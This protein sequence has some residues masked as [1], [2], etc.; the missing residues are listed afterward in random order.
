MPKTQQKGFILIYTL[1]IAAVIAVVIGITIASA[2]TELRISRDEVESLKAFYAADTGIECV[3]FYQ[4][5]YQAFDTTSPRRKYNCG[6]GEDFWAGVSPPTDECEE[7]TYN[8]SLEG[9]SNGSCAD[10]T[11]QIIP[12]TIYIDGSP[13]KVCRAKV[14]ANGKNSC[15][16][17]G[18]N[19]V[20]RT[21]WEDM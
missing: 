10:V 15:S 11:V 14:T 3:R 20:E 18:S 21:R 6:V 4:N 7:H 5:N 16:A 8:F 17:T 13:V 1:L 9:F 19:L 12:Q 2:M